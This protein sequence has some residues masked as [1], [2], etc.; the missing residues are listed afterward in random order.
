MDLKLEFKTSTGQDWV[1]EGGAAAPRAPAVIIL[2][3]SLAL[4][5]IG[6]FLNFNRFQQPKPA[7]QEK[8]AAAKPE[9][10]AKKQTR[11]N[12]FLIVQ[13]KLSYLFNLNSN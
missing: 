13:H 9:E 3:L 11:F 12:F 5:G 10:G 2:I 8:A 4:K 7:K 1:P 6:H